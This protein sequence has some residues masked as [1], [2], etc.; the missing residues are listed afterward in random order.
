MNIGRGLGWHCPALLWW[1]LARWV[2]RDSFAALWTVPCWAPLSMAFPGQ[3]YCSAL[4]FP[5][6][7]KLPDP[8]IERTCISR[9]GRKILHCR[10]TWEEDPYTHVT[11]LG[12]KNVSKHGLS[13]AEKVMLFGPWD[14]HVKKPRVSTEGWNEIPCGAK[15]NCP[16]RG[17]LRTTSLTTAW[18]VNRATHSRPPSCIWA[19][20]WKDYSDERQ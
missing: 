4:P 6:A 11:C 1:R 13:G 8:G 15:T 2:M 19:S 5:S 17:S 16:S 9:T 12:Q 7:G 10:A 3:E 14:N 18:H 20:Q